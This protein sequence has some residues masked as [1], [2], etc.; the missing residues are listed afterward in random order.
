MPCITI[1]INTIGKADQLTCEVGA[2]RTALPE[3]VRMYIIQVVASVDLFQGIGHGRNARPSL[4]GGYAKPRYTRQALKK[5]KALGTSSPSKL[6]RP[7]P[8]C[9]VY[10]LGHLCGPWIGSFLL[11]GVA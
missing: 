8:F 3:Q 10:P 11:R 1:V 7:N 4:P 6:P 5:A 2:A 9:M